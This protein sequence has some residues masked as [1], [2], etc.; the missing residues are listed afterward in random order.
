MAHVNVFVY[1]SRSGRM[2]IKEATIHQATHGR[3]RD[4]MFAI[5]NSTGIQKIV[6]MKPGMLYNGMIWFEQRNDNLA[7]DIFI[8]AEQQKI[9][10]A[11]RKIE[12]FKQKI[13]DIHCEW[14]E[15]EE[16]FNE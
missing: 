8:K 1:S 10:S 13:L 12:D 6:C 5:E 4:L 11:Q 3:Q 15:D 7:R 2:T 14:E 16:D 9:K